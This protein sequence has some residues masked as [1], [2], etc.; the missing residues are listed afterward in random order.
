MKARTLWEA[1]PRLPPFGRRGQADADIPTC[2]AYRK[3]PQ[4]PIFRL[5]HDGQCKRSCGIIKT[6]SS[7]IKE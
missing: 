1:S 7:I 5:A 4:R 6:Q 3:Q 2:P